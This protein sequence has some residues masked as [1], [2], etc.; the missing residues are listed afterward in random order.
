M[1]PPEQGTTKRRA[2]VTGASRGIG[3]AVAERLAASGHSVALCSRSGASDL[4][5]KLGGIDV[6]A[7]L[8]TADGVE[9]AVAEAEESLGGPVEV[10]VNCAGMTNDGLLARLSDEDWEAVFATNLTSV[11]RTSRRVLRGMMKARWGRIVSVGSVVGTI[12]NPGQS[13]YAATKAGIVGF[14]KALAKEIASR[15]ITV[16]VVAPGFIETDMTAALDDAQR[17]AALAQIPMGR[18]GEAYEVAGAV[19]Y[20]VSEEASYVSGSVLTVDGAM[21]TG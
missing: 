3:A 16:N 6:R 19:A 5:S 4:A 20:L 21:G 2:L 18:F 8:S 10:L 12:G 1:T 9:A 7:D 13:A 11:M 15:N 17:T 14:S